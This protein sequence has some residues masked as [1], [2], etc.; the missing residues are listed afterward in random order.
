M[1]TERDFDRLARAWLELGPDEAP[2][3]VVAAV[4]QA[5]Q[6]THQVRRP[7]RWPSWRSFRMNRIPMALGATAI[8]VAVIGGGILLNQ[9]NQSGVGSGGAGASTPSPAASP[10]HLSSPSASGGL[11][12]SSDV[13]RELDPGMYR[14][15]GPF[16]VPFAI[17]FPS[18]WSLKSLAQGDVQFLNTAVNGGNGA[19]WVSLDLVENVFADPCHTAGGPIKPPVPSTVD[20]VVT[21]LTR[22]VGFSA[23]PVSDVVVGGY[24][25]KV[26][27]LT[28][29]IDTDTAGCTGNAPGM[30][31]MFTFRGG[32]SGA[33]NGGLNDGAREH[34]S[35]IDVAGTLV[36]IDRETFDE[37]LDASIPEADTIVQS[38]AFK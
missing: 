31:P 11:L 15:A 3:R 16:D 21:A 27:E 8:L 38:L 28:N 29:S 24:A 26:I 10:S 34:I 33:T 37:T 25:G 9:R 14:V 17:R 2:D 22:M 1:T 36:L 20:G 30:L 13:N 18:G 23:G 19:A 6:T 35:V 4:L 12:D 5:A 7:T 32:G